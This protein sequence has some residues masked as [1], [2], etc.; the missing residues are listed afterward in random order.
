LNLSTLNT[1]SLK[2]GNFFHF[3]K[4]H[5]GVLLCFF[6]F[7][8]S[9]HSQNNTTG[10]YLAPSTRL[11]G[12]SSMHY[13]VELH[14]R[15]KGP[16]DIN[17][18]ISVSNLNALSQACI[19]FKTKN[20][21]T[22]PFIKKSAFRLRQRPNV[23]GVKNQEQ[24]APYKSAPFGTSYWFYNLVSRTTVSFGGLQTRKQ[25]HS[26]QATVTDYTTHCN[27]TIAQATDAASNRINTTT[28]LVLPY[29]GRPP[30][31]FNG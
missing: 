31:A 30:P 1:S 27:T 29:F 10:I 25:T 12:L 15:T 18:N 23:R 14:N 9:L 22:T 17:E 26:P 16:R 21:K 8:V 13:K 5:S 2:E 3:C 7:V 4:K 6:C 20:F 24:A 19:S 11:S 28:R